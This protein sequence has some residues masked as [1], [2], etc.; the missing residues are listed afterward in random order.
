MQITFKVVSGKH[1]GQKLRITGPQFLIGRGDE[2]QLRPNSDL[3]SRNH[4]VVLVGSDGAVIRDLQSRNGTF[5]NH[6]R[7]TGDRQLQSGDRLTIGQ[8]SFEVEIKTSDSAVSPANQPVVRPRILDLKEAAERPVPKDEDDADVMEWM[9]EQPGIASRDTV[10]LD[11]VSGSGADLNDT[12]VVRPP[13]GDEEQSAKPADPSKS[14][15]AHNR[16][17]PHPHAKDSVEAASMALK[18]LFRSR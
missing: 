15:P 13:A 1:A 16:P 5:V 12:I 17:S 9:K 18:N 11:A 2:C 7:I 14:A 4:C 6:E 3:V 8:L 10:R